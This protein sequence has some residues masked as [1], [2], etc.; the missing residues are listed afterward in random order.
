MGFAMTLSRGVPEHRRARRTRRLGDGAGLPLAKTARRPVVVV[1][2]V[3]DAGVGFRHSLE[4]GTAPT[5]RDRWDDAMAL[6]AAS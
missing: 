5:A 2:A 6:E 3:C 4:S 1:I